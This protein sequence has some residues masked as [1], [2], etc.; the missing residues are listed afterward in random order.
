MRFSKH[1]WRTIFGLA[2][3]LLAPSSTRSGAQTNASPGAMGALTLKVVDSVS[4]QGIA[5]AK[6]CIVVAGGRPHLTGNWTTDQSGTI[7]L[8]I[9]NSTDYELKLWTI[10]DGYIPAQRSL[11]RDLLGAFPETCTVRLERAEMV[12]GVVLNEAGKPVAGVEVFVEWRKNSELPDPSVVAPADSN[13]HYEKTDAK[14]HWTCR[15]APRQL[16]SA[17]FRFIHPNYVTVTMAPDTAEAPQAGAVVVSEASL[18][19]CAAVVILKRGLTL[20]GV[21]L[22]SKHKPI[23]GA[24]ATAGDYPLWTPA[25]GRFTFNNRP[26]GETILTVE[27]NGFAPQRKQFLLTPGQEEARIEL[28]QGRILKVRVLDAK[29]KAVPGARMAL[30]KP[31]LKAGSPWQG[32]TDVNGRLVWASAPADEASYS[33]SRPGYESA[34]AQKLKADGQ[35]QVIT[36]HKH[37]HIS[38]RVLDFATRAPITA[39]RVVPGVLHVDHHDWN[40]ALVT[41]GHNGRYALAVPTRDLPHLVRVEADG[42]Y[43]ETSQTFQESE[44]DAVADFA[45]QRGEAIR[46]TVQWP[47]GKPAAKAQAVLCLEGR[48][49]LLADARIMEADPSEISETDEQGRFL[50]Q[51]RREVKMIAVSHEQGYAEVSLED[52]K[53]SKVIQLRPWGRV[54]GR[55]F[56]GSV[57]GTNELV[58][59]VRLGSFSPRFQVNSFTVLTDGQGRFTFEHV[60]PGPLLIGRWIEA[61]F[62]HSRRINVASGQTTEAPLGVGGRT[63]TAEV[64]AADG[65]ALHWEA[66][67]QPAFLHAKL[68]SLTIPQLADGLATNA[69][70]RAYWDSEA[71]RARQISDVSYTLQLGSNNVFHVENVPPGN[72]ELEI[73]YHEL[74]PRENE[75]DNC[76]GILRQ[77]VVIPQLPPGQQDEPCNLGRMIITLKPSAQ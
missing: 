70:W 1:D 59:L 67:Y 76:L 21:V 51:P 34:L 38:G 54:T 55:L 8:P 39:F 46:G 26:P 62:S 74:S 66:T 53:Q 7:E 56:V 11:E 20:R 68:P 47:D 6:L 57:P 16:Q 3:V 14:G 52:F 17:Q 40:Q 19:A 69:W 30:E 9:P 77:E 2:L 15:H 23:E 65:R 24:E 35:E 28:E 10:A 37:L 72:Y 12:G 5:G 49:P 18:R 29:G 41:L 44:E 50:F 22:D 36:L 13:F 71:G 42:Y 73:H 31:E 63:V 25:D 43:P 45:L 32:E 64:V 4:E 60:P 58:Q 33:I 48:T 75:P 61:R 27:A